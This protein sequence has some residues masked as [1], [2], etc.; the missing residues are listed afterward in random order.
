MGVPEWVVEV[1]QKVEQSIGW[2]RFSLAAFRPLTGCPDVPTA[3]IQ[4][5]PFPMCLCRLLFPF[6]Y[7][8]FAWQLRIFKR[9]HRRRIAASLSVATADA[10][11]VTNRWSTV[12]YAYKSA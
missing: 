5:S 6:R 8:P 2:S 3:M 9:G 10:L 1:E 7:L 12:V 11:S 4:R